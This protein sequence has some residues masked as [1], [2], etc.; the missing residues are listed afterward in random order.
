MRHYSDTVILI[1][2]LCVIVLIH[3][4]KKPMQPEYNGIT[5]VKI[6]ASGKTEAQNRH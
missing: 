1:N 4:F 6:E 2:V 5:R 3:L